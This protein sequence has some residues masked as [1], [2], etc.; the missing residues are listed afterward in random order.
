[1][2][3]DDRSDGSALHAVSVLAVGR[4]EGSRGVGV[5]LVR[6]SLVWPSVGSM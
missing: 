1:M 5:P 4:G 3:L 6:D 2:G